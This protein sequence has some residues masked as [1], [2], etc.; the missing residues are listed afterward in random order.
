[1]GFS[2]DVSVMSIQEVLEFVATNALS[3]SLS[4][5]GQSK[6][7]MLYFHDGGI[8]IP[9]VPPKRKSGR[10]D[11]SALAALLDRGSKLS[12]SSGKLQTLPESNGESATKAKPKKKRA[13]SPDV[14]EK[15]LSAA[16]DEDPRELAKRVE[17]AILDALQWVQTRFEFAP[18]ALP[19]H[20]SKQM[21][22]GQTLSFDANSILM[23]DARRLD[24][25]KRISGVIGMLEAATAARGDARNRRDLHGDLTGIGFAAVLQSLNTQRR[26]GTLTVYTSDREESLYFSRGDAFVLLRQ[27]VEEGQFARDFLGESWVDGV[28]QKS[29]E[30]E[31]ICVGLVPIDELSEDEQ[32]VVKDTFLDVLF[33]D[34]AQFVFLKDDL[35]AD[36]HDPGRTVGK[37]ALKTRGFLMEAIQRLTEWD[38]VRKV[39]GSRNAVLDFMDFEEKMN[40]SKSVYG[41]TLQVLTLIDGNLS[42]EQ[43]VNLSGLGYL[44]VGRIVKE[45]LEDG[46]LEV[47]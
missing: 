9:A 4:V 7:M 35:P 20:V 31:P 44:E 30:Q 22:S 6:S 39:V 17:D 3:G 29:V 42:F 32:R 19:A 26:S 1:M 16:G 24:D 45:L 10:I 25:S 8:V 34:E 28:E 40:Q 43:I 46:H 12:K 38:E 15:I 14:I 47:L 23:E 33:W 13:L 37:V 11:R 18:G 27:E 2:G 41:S 36:F 5:S 21:R